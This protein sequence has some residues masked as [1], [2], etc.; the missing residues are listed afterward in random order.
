MVDIV[1]TKFRKAYG[2]LFMGD[3]VRRHSSF[4]P[5]NKLIH[6]TELLKMFDRSKTNLLSLPRFQH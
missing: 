5:S 6:Y 3:I 2:Y 1:F 4:L